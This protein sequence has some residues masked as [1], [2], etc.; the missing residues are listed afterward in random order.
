LKRHESVDPKID[1]LV[2]ALYGEMTDADRRDFD[3]QLKVDAALRTE[4]EE[5][6]GTRSLLA[7]WEVEDRIPSFLVVEAGGRNRRASAAGWLE[8]FRDRFG[9]WFSVGGWV[10][11]GAAAAVLLLALK[12]V[13]LQKTDGGFQV[14]VGSRNRPVTRQTVDPLGT[15]PLQ[16]SS[17]GDAGTSTAA[18]LTR[19][20]FDKYSAAML[21]MVSAYMNEY[22]GRR[23]QEIGAALRSLYGDINAK[24]SSQYA[25]LLGKIDATRPADRIAH[26]FLRPMELGMSHADSLGPLLSP[27]DVEVG[28]NE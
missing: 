16:V 11:A 26:D 28:R 7:D 21:R 25:D 17:N 14:N 20:E 9:S 19:D 27:E 3:A 1:R 23:D 13:E 15:I 2:A 22:R 12:G 8:G 24:Q 6:S 4:W 10:V 18:Y 5:L